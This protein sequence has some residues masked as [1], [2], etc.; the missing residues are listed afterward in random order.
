MSARDF[1][2]KSD[3]QTDKKEKK[4]GLEVGKNGGTKMKLEKDRKTE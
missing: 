2:R 1:N 3:R 4:N